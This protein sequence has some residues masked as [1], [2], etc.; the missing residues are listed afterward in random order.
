MPKIEKIYELWF[1]LAY[2]QLIVAKKM[3]AAIRPGRRKC[4]APKCTNESET[5]RIKILLK[6]G[7]EAKGL[8]PLFDK[9]ET[10]VKID[11]IIMKSLKDLTVKDLKGC[12]PD[13]KTPELA[14]YH[15]ALIYNQEFKDE[16]IISIIYFKY[17]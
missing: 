5:A 7:D 14:K 4:P 3:T 13:C 6:P 15:L 9:F 11:K 16:D 12:S 17:L 2:K 8:L 10:L 1:R